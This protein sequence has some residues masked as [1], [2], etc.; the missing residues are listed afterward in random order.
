MTLRLITF[1]TFSFVLF[2][3]TAKVNEL[4]QAWTSTE[5]HPNDKRWYSAPWPESDISYRLTPLTVAASATAAENAIVINPTERF[6]SLCH[7]QK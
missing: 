7:P 2:S 6:H 3:A 4:P 1:M 5:L